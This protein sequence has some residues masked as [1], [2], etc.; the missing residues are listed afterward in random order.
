MRWWNMSKVVYQRFLAKDETQ[1][2]PNSSSFL[3]PD[4]KHTYLSI[5]S[6]IWRQVAF[7]WITSLRHRCMHKGLQ[8]R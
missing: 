2:A 4:K 6:H 8:Q 5:T 1:D 7:S 3:F